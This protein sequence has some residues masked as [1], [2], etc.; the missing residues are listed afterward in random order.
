MVNPLN[1]LG[2]SG[3]SSRRKLLGASLALALPAAL[4]ISG[5]TLAS[6]ASTQPAAAPLAPAYNGA[7]HGGQVIVVLKQQQAGM[8]LRTQAR[9]R[10]TAAHADQA[11]VVASI[12]S[13][14]GTKVTQLTAPDAVAATLS[15]AEVARLRHNPAVAEIVPNARIQV[16][17]VHT[18]AAPPLRASHATVR[19]GPGPRPGHGREP[20]TIAPLRT[21]VIPPNCPSSPVQEPEAVADIHASDGNPNAP[22][23]GNSIATG[24]G[25][26][27]AN[28]GMNQLAGDPDLQ[29]ADGSHVVIDAPD[30]TADQ[31][32][33]ETFEDA[34]SVGAQGLITYQ[35]SKALPFSNVSPGCTFTIKGDA[36]DASLVDLTE[37]DTPILGLSQIIAGIDSA[38]TTVHADVISESFG[39]TSLPTSRSGQLLAEADNAAVAA[40]VT[41]VESSGDSGPQGTMITAA[42]DPAVIA[43]G[44]V[45]NLHIV[46]LNDGYHSYVSNNMAAQSSGATAPTGKVVDLVASD[47]F[48]GET[49]CAPLING[50]PDDYP[51]EAA[52]GTSEASPL[53]A[54]AAADVIQAYR[55]THNGASPAPAMVKDI[56]TGTATSID[57]PADQQGAGLLNVYAAVRAA[58]QMPGTTYGR[59]PDD[60]PSLISTP[61]QLD[62]TG[63]GGSVSDQSVSLYNASTRPTT[64]T[65]S[66]RWI[67]PEFPISPVTTENVSAPDPSLPVPEAGATAASDIT[68]NVPPHLSRLD[69]DMIWPDPANSNVLEFVLFNPQGAIVQESYDDGTPGQAGSAPNDQHAEV[70]DPTPGRWTARFLWG[71][72]DDYVELPP[73]APGTYTGPMS[74]R[75]SGQDYQTAPATRPVTI[76]PRSSV[77][78]P[79]RVVMPVQPGD[80]PESLQLQGSN[81]TADSVPIARRT[82]IPSD[83]GSFQARIIG[84]SARDVG[85]INTYEINVPAGAPSL[86]VALHATDDSADNPFRY[87]LVSPSGTV[88]A[89]ASTPQTV[90]GQVTGDAEL[91]TT[92]PAAGIWQIDV[93]LRLTVSGDEF[94]QTVFGDVTDGGGG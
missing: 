17:Q 46:A 70:T 40:G 87:Y 89:T 62:I 34:A 1:P 54:G 75:V 25:V 9:R 84:T 24:Q 91:S 86:N 67:G 57:A 6:A 8:N 88:V 53:I 14:G 44:G 35:Y 81:G 26:I 85:Q 60:T 83:G 82:L 61:S 77:S 23:E 71:G 73:A 90:N 32:N 72:I 21:H 33:D 69:A 38:V 50:C 94:T 47:W 66:Y 68:F 11:P 30:Y 48:G 29:R 36:P 4:A 10:T 49:D 56:L 45:D 39:S 5:G 42:D 3:R 92:S 58:Q 27:I 41:V 63:N 12:R 74:F 64:V 7:P 59:G 78:V 79:L 16:S 55:D 43:A 37:I 51:I 28:E 22:G 19:P 13:H 18:E 52:A 2:L 31:G 76:A 65:G 80:S 20:Q 15:A 93:V